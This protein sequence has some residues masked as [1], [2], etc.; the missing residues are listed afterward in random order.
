VL[1]QHYGVRPPDVNTTVYAAFP[2]YP[3]HATCPLLTQKQSQAHNLAP[4]L[5]MPNA[6]R[7]PY[8]Q[9]H[10]FAESTD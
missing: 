5:A 2:Q 3:P 4:N 7:N 9:K 8:L 10:C 1:S 6:E